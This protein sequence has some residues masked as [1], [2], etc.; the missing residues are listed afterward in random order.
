M[1][2][3]ENA[4]LELTGKSGN[5]N[6][7][8][9]APSLWGR[10]KLQLQPTRL[11]ESTQKIIARRNCTVLLTQIDSVEIVEEGNPLWLALGFLTISFLVGIIFFVLYFVIKHKYLV[12]RSGSNFQLVM[13]D[14][15]NE[16]KAEQFINAVLKRAEELQPQNFRE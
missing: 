15:S 10:T 16:S 3:R 9:V 14:S 2:N 4:I 1:L 12:I 8:V 13:L 7:G 6:Y 11:V 5:S